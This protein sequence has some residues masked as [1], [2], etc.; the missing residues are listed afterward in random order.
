MF[1]VPCELDDNVTYKVTDEFVLS[2]TPSNKSHHLKKLI[3]Y[4]N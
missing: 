3:F 4:D 1:S 2:G